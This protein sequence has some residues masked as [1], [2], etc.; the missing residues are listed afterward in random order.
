MYL[1]YLARRRSMTHNDSM[2]K[3]NEEMKKNGFINLA[4][5]HTKKS[6]LSRFSLNFY[7]KALDYSMKLLLVMAGN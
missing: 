5:P 7:T 3:I 6:L 1:V 4:G 2:K